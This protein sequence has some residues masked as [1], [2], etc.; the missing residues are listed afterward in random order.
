M[1]G[2]DLFFLKR[3][4]GDLLLPPTGFLLL[5]LAGFVFA[6]IRW[7][8]SVGRS[9]PRRQRVTDAG[10]RIH[11]WRV[12]PVRVGNG[13]TVVGILLALVSSSPTAGGLLIAQLEA[14]YE[15]LDAPP[16]RLPQARAVQWK[17]A[18]A[19]APQAI[20]VLSG[21][22][23]PD[24]AS[25]PHDNR[26]SSHSVARAIHA[27]RLARQTRLPLLISGGTV[28]DGVMPEA[29]AMKAL[30][31]R[32]LSVPVRWVEGRSR[33]TA[34]NAEFSARILV[35]AGIQRVLL[36]TQAFHMQ[37]AEMLFTRA[38][39]TVIPAPH[40]FRGASFEQA[41]ARPVPSLEGLS[42]TWLASR[43]YLGLLWYRVLP[44]LYSIGLH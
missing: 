33:D 27:A 32:D 9:L 20:V 15:L 18:P 37:R 19:L 11:A 16:E 35:P 36:V 41:I 25:S 29:E 39:L 23:E 12:W 17:A 30:I 22:L 43:E 40:G 3:L 42:D 7:F 6:R 44:W 28:R 34:E 38:G 26:L 14:P 8:Q 24:G 1:E 21:G 5:A 2:S 13:L 31:E 4:L 10:L